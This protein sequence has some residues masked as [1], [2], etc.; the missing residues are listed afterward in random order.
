VTRR[1][2]RSPPAIRS[3]ATSAPATPRGTSACVL[4]PDGD[5]FAAISGGKVAVATGAIER[6]V[7]GGLKLTSGETI[8]AD[9]VVTA[10]GLNMRLLGGIDLSVDGESVRASEHFIYKGMMLSGVPNLFVAFGYTN[11]S[12]TLRADL[13]ARS[14]CRLLNAMESK[15][16]KVC[17]ARP[18]SDLERR[19]VMELT[20]GYVSRA[21][22]GLPGQGDRQPW[23]VPQH[24]LKDA[25]GMTLRPIDEGLE[26]A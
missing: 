9:V 20:S 3:N 22:A 7:P 15:R 14:V 11:A 18:P 16:Q 2:R 12:W 13:T 24:Y 23:R 1:A 6:F 17:V 26:L 25:A 8:A 10:T 5:F 21:A 19:P 4:I